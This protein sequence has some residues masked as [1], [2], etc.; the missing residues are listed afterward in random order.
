MR[1]LEAFVGVIPLP[2]KDNTKATNGS[3]TRQCYAKVARIPRI[4]SEFTAKL[5][6]ARAQTRKQ[7]R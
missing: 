3:Q 4:S 7:R 1:V 6:V 2:A 5:G